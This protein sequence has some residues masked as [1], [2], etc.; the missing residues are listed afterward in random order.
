M[1]TTPVKPYTFDTILSQSETPSQTGPAP[2]KFVLPSPSQEANFGPPPSQFQS[3]PLQSAQYQWS[4]QNHVP[5]YA[6]YQVPLYPTHAGTPSQSSSFSQVEVIAHV[7][8]MTTPTKSTAGRAGAKAGPGPRKTTKIE[9]KGYVPNWTTEEREQLLGWLSEDLTNYE[10]WKTKQI[11]IAEQ[12]SEDLFQGVRSA[13]AIKNQWDLMK[14]KYT[15]AKERLSATGEGQREDED[16]WT[17]IRKTWLDHECPYYEEM[18]DILR[19]DKSFTPFYVSE[20][21]AIKGSHTIIEGEVVDLNSS[22]DDE[23]DLHPPAGGKKQPL[24]RGETVSNAAGSESKRAIKKTKLT[25]PE[26]AIKSFHDT[27]ISLD[28]ERL[29]YEKD[30]DEQDRRFAREKDERFHEREMR[31]LQLQ[32]QEYE[33]RLEIFKHEMEKLRHR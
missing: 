13:S 11:R 30:R 23:Y 27:T 16:K 28:K 20:S 33:L 31:R 25:G 4:Q 8:E 3:S 7:P 26:A 15:K 24:R 32:E 2:R 19:R 1:S 18:D 29:Q 12:L 9:K 6:P 10:L 5:L 21:G 17:S 14:A 22:S